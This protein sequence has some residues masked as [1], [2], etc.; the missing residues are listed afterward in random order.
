MH[1]DPAQEERR[2]PPEQIAGIFHLDHHALVTLPG[3][4]NGQ[5]WVR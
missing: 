3:K 5:H 4:V 1:R 2:Q